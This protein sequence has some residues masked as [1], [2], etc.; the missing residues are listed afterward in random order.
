M[1]DSCAALLAKSGIIPALIE[2]LNGILPCL[3]SGLVFQRSLVHVAVLQLNVPFIF[4]CKARVGVL[5]R[6]G[7]ITLLLMERY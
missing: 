3:N 6:K 2:L 1:D 5:Y 4:S 7:A